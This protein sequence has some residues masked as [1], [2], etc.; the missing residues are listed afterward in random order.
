MAA[1]R[2]QIESHG[3]AA[4]EI[5]QSLHVRL[6]Q[7]V[8]VDVVAHAGTVRRG[9]FVS[10]DIERRTLAADGLKRG[11]DEVSLRLV[12]LADRTFFI[13]SGGVEIAKAYIVKTV[14]RSVGLQ[15]LFKN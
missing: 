10:K 9:V 11:G 15:R 14:G 13:R 7:I 12:Y 2:P 1:A 3:T 6:R 8:H 4:V 5:L